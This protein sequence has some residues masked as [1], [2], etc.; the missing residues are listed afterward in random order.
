MN[1]VLLVAIFKPYWSG[2]PV[3]SKSRIV[4]RCANTEDSPVEGDNLPTSEEDNLSIEK[5]ADQIA[6]AAAKEESRF[7]RDGLEEL[8]GMDA[9]AFAAALSDQTL[10]RRALEP[11]AKVEGVI[12]SFGGGFVI[13]D[14]GAKSE[15][16]INSAE[17]PDATIG[18]VVQAFVARLSDTGV[19]LTTRLDGDAASG[20]IE[21]AAAQK[22]PIDGTV[23][24]V[25]KGGFTVA[26]G[27]LKAFCPISQISL[28][29]IDTP[30]QFLQQ[31]LS[32]LVIEHEE[33]VVLSRR[34][35]LEAEAEK[36]AQVTWGKLRAGAPV[37]GNVLS[38]HP[39]GFFVDLG[40]VKALVPRRFAGEQE[41]DPAPGSL[42]KGKVLSID[43]QN[44]KLSVAPMGA[45]SSDSAPKI[46]GDTVSFG[47]MAD[48]LSGKKF[49]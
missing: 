45:S 41:Q 11:G 15:G 48:L 4:R 12:T 33:K 34:A 24:A 38:T 32:F 28:E 3:M 5:L 17:L 35:L 47:I 39:F 44:S 25:N 1:T 43:R 19:R 49:R 7:V 16:L 14:I 31:T 23:I 30:E 37:S 18:Q 2:V 8:A 22:L 20:L 27:S 42:F 36:Q 21:E 26:I 40:G 29:R 9:S 10:T 46:I 13:V 6:P